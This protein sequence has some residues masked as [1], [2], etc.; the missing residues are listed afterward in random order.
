MD[1]TLLSIVLW[2]RKKQQK[3]AIKTQ[4]KEVWWVLPHSPIKAEGD[5]AQ[6]NQII[7]F[8]YMIR[9]LVF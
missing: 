4:Y 3:I 6:K 5:V 1:A 9:L 2:K 7:L 8:F